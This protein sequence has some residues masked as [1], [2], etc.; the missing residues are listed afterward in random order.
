MLEAFPRATV[1]RPSILFAENG[2][3]VN[4]LADIIA[5][6]PVVP[7]FAPEARLQLLFVDDAADAVAAA[8]ADPARHAG[9]TYEIAGPEALE[10]MELH[11]RIARG[12]GASGISCPCPTAWPGSSPRCRAPR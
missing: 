11:R 1:L 9:K 10:V 5:T 2:G 8:L 7:V 4:M 12:Q 3:F 6:F